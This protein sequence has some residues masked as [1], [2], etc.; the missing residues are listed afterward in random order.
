MRIEDQ[1][2][3]EGE[4]REETPKASSK[5]EEARRE[6]EVLWNLR[7]QTL[8]NSSRVFKGS[9]S[10]QG[11]Q[12]VCFWKVLRSDS[13]HSEK[14]QRNQQTVNRVKA[15]HRDH[16]LVSF[17]C[18]EGLMPSVLIWNLVWERREGVWVDLLLLKV[19]HNHVST[20]HEWTRKDDLLPSRRV[21]RMGHSRFVWEGKDDLRQISLI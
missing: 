10:R 9:L 14:G 4:G 12:G 6:K 15:T 19:R 13:R 17:I 20:Q 21:L 16:Q 11:Q 5:G 18:G 2:K 7:M 3:V 8:E 1:R